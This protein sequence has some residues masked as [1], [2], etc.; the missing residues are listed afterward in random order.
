MHGER[1]LILL[2]LGSGSGTSCRAGFNPAP[3]S[4]GLCS[5]PEPTACQTGAS[6]MHAAGARPSEMG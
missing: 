6:P 4:L 2:G 5:L 1:A 3:A